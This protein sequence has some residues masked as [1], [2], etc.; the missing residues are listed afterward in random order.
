MT[1]R[2]LRSHASA[3]APRKG[4]EMNQG[5]FEV[6]HVLN[7]DGG[8][9]LKLSGELDLASAQDLLDT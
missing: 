7:H 1:P 5:G 8:A 6:H 3:K 4:A 9:V 2:L